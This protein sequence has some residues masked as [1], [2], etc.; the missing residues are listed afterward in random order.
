MHLHEQMHYV[1]IAGEHPAALLLPMYKEPGNHWAPQFLESA[2]PE[3]EQRY[4]ESDEAREVLKPLEGLRPVATVKPLEGM[5]PMIWRKPPDALNLD[6]RQ[7]PLAEAKFSLS[8]F[9]KLDPRC[10]MHARRLHAVATVART[11]SQLQPE[12]LARAVLGPA[13]F[14]ALTEPAAQ[15]EE[16]AEALRFDPKLA[17]PDT[18]LD[19]YWD[20]LFKASALPRPEV[21]GPR[22]CTGELRMLKLGDDTDPVPTL[23]TVFE[24]DI[25][26]DE[27]VRFCDPMTWTCFPSWCGMKKWKNGK[28]AAKNGGK[29]DWT[30]D[31][32]EPAI[33]KYRESVSFDCVGKTM[34]ELTV[35]LD[36]NTRELDEGGQRVVITEYRLSQ[37][38]Q[39]G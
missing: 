5:K 12:E 25:P 9:A 18:A 15:S 6:P 7:L 32:G 13:Q 38:Q 22:P 21:V 19:V 4:L 2:G 34:P 24:A 36:F 26:F 3:I 37:T 31:K 28:W 35:D 33:R 23:T 10:R 27:A 20:G 11:F 14:G 17:D 16:L 8:Q 1:D 30:D 39:P 29:A